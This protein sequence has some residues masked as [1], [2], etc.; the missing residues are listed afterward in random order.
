M[1]PR[2]ELIDCYFEGEEP[3]W[4]MLMNAECHA[5]R[6]IIFGKVVAQAPADDT[7]AIS[8]IQ[9]VLDIGLHLIDSIE[10]MGS[11]I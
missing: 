7:R 10:V 1:I 3:L 9:Q 11:D 4:K 2:Q 8:E 5:E 6:V